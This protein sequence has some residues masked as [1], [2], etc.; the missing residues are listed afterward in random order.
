MKLLNK[1]NIFFLGVSLIIFSLGGILFYLLFQIT[2]DNGINAKL[3]ERKEYNLKQIVRSDSMML[4]FQKYTDVLSIKPV[5]KIISEKENLS[6]T[7][8]YDSVDNQFIQYRQLSFFKQVNGHNYFIQVRRA[9]LDHTSLLKDVFILEGL[10]FL[11]FI[12]VLT[13]VNNQV[14]KKLWTPFYF[15]LDKINNYKIE[16]AQNLSL[17]RSSI[18]EFNELAIAIEKMSTKI[19]DEFN[20]LKEFTENASHEI[21]TPLAII[22]NKLEILLQAPGLSKDQMDLISSASAATNRLSKLNEALIIL[23]KIENRQFHEVED[24]SVNS[25]IDRILLSMEE[26]IKIKSISIERH[27]HEALHIKMHPYLAEILLE[28]LVINS[29]KHNT[30][31]GSISITTDSETLEIVNS[32]NHSSGNV[33]KLFQRFVKSNPKSQS[34]G[35]GLSIV[36]AICDTYSFNVKYAIENGYHKIRITFRK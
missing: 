36:K 14:S 24:I 2:I 18:N 29:I 1:T 25:N 19:N 32:G 11:A 22:K 23:S 5:D 7:L 8:I 6:D 13:I 12:T 31:P 28:N 33:E 30:T 10:L 21:Q 27:F 20:I 34:L 15:I 4:L 35:L 9:I 16:L 17:P 3:H 26:L